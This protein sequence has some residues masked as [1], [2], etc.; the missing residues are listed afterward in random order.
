MTGELR[1]GWAEPGDGQGIADLVVECFLPDQ[2][3]LLIYGCAGAAAF[4]ED[5]IAYQARGGDSAFIV[6]KAHRVLGFVELRRLADAVCLNYMATSA[7]ARGQGV[8]R[9][10]MVAAVEAG[11]AEGVTRAVHDVFVGN[12][13]REF[14]EKVGYRVVDRVIWRAMPLSGLE[15]GRALF[16]GLPQADVAHTRFGFSRFT[17]TTASGRYEVGRLGT[18]WFRC[19]APA[20]LSDRDA[21]AAL[22]RLDPKREVL[23]LLSATVL[24]P[25]DLLCRVVLESERLEGDS[26][27]VLP[28]LRGK[29]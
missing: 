11:L 6:A 22:H 16:S 26:A 9:R 21:L 23:S 8:Y 4:A 18:K 28:G 17:V 27:A 3:D 12:T 29:S 24:W 1:F 13:I 15:G 7:E 25:E 10:L 19:M 2:R 20:I 14:H 5:C